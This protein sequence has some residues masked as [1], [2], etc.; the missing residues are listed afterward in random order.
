MEQVLVA[1][2]IAIRSSGLLPRRHRLL[3]GEQALGELTVGVG[4]TA[5]FSDAEGRLLR[6]RRTSLWRGEY[7]MWEGG[8][9]LG[10]ASQPLF[11]RRFD[12]RF[13]GGS[14]LLFPRGLG[15]YA[16]ELRDETGAALLTLRWHLFSGGEILLHAPVEGDLLAFVTYLTLMRR[17]VARR[18]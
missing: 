2:R 12:V 6:F 9:V 3:A 15:L 5:A 1:D 4:F 17:R 18:R 7:G 11:Q 13:A 16:W 14:F 10:S 8:Q